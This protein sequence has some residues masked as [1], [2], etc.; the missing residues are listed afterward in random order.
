MFPGDTTE[1]QLE[2]AAEKLTADE[3]SEYL[4]SIKMGQYSEEFAANDIDGRL[5]WALK[6]GDLIDF[7]IDNG[8]HRRKILSKFKPFLLEKRC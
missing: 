7:G 5:M 2:K 8:F 3:V 6:D 4:R 1:E